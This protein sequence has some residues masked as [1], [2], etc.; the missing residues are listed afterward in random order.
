MFLMLAVHVFYGITLT[1]ENSAANP[2]KYAKSRKLKATFAGE[3]MI[4]TGLLILAFLVYHLLQFTFRVTPDILP[5]A[6]ANRPGDV[7][8]MVVGSFRITAISLVYV[9]AMVTLFFHSSH[10]IQSFVQTLGWNNDNTLPKV[11]MV[12]KL[13][14][15][16]FLLGYSAIPVFIL[17]GILKK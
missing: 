12:G 16:I 13:I 10:G 11:T 5:A 2:S 1:L 9:A 7:Y 3:T 15:V 17:A 6:V 4:W 8:G 14:S